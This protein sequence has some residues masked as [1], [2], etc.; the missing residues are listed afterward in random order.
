[1]GQKDSGHWKGPQI[2][3]A[4][5]VSHLLFWDSELM[6]L[7]PGRA[8]AVTAHLRFVLV[9]FGLEILSH[10]NIRLRHQ[11]PLHYAQICK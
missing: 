3:K 8:A 1:M 7:W 9:Y 5:S 11:P 4:A 2:N 6:V 10:E